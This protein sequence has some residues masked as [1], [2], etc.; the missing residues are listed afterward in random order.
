METFFFCTDNL[1]DIFPI[2]DNGWIIYTHNLTNGFR[3]LMQ[4][5]TIQT[6]GLSVTNSTA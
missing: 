2:L 6:Q 3:Q 4:E 5:R 1:G